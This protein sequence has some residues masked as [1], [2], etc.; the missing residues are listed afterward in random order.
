MYIQ[1]LRSRVSDLP[2][3]L[4][5]PT[6]IL[7]NS[8]GLVLLVKHC[9]GIWGL[10]GGL[11]E[12]GESVEGALKRE[13]YEELNINVDELYYFKVFS[14]DGFSRKGNSG[15]ENHYVAITYTSRTYHGLIKIDNTEVIE[16]GFFH[17][18]ELP[19]NTM[20]MTKEIILFYV[21]GDDCSIK[22]AAAHP[23]RV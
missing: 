5:R 21:N 11:L 9:D 6:L 3:I 18:D 22:T 16:Y 19:I 17:F 4:V 20:S 14:G 10:P 12:P 2:L 23:E 8:N 15:A 7:I 1:E 13:L